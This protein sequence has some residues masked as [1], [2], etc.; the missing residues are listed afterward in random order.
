MSVRPGWWLPL[1]FVVACNWLLDNEERSYDVDSGVDAGA[2]RGGSAGAAAHGGDADAGADSDDAG[3]PGPGGHQA[4]AGASDAGPPERDAGQPDAGRPDQTGCAARIRACSPGDSAEEAAPCGPCDSGMKIVSRV[5]TDACTW[6]PPSESSCR[7]DPVR[8]DPGTTDTHPEPCGA[9][10]LGE[11]SVTRVCSATCD[12]SEPTP[13]PC[14]GVPET[15]CEAGATLERNVPCDPNYCNKGVQHQVATC[16]AQCSWGDYA[17]SGACNIDHARFCRPFNLG[18][19][20]PFRCCAPGSWEHCYDQ[21]TPAE[22]TWTGDCAA[23]GGDQ[24]DC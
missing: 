6:A 21:G 16:T 9:C 14:L 2:A 17:N 3:K 4:G 7:I 5:C 1:C 11:R 10:N 15:A 8:C 23:C 19:R 24:C 12:W 22:C 13:G 18:G 20:P